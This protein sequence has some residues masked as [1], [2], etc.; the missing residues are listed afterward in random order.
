MRYSKWEWVKLGYPNTGWFILNNE[1]L[2]HPHSGQQA[3]KRPCPTSAGSCALQCSNGL[4]PVIQLTRA[5]SHKLQYWTTLAMKS[6][7]W[8]VPQWH[9]CFH[10]HLTHL[11]H[12]PCLVNGLQ[13]ISVRHVEGVHVVNPEAMFN[14]GRADRLDMEIWAVKH[15]H[16]HNSSQ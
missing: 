16:S 1:I 2:I 9:F 8:S 7:Y 5:V 15:Q 10:V 14:L 4:Q 6:V 3:G 13:D 12:R 11:R